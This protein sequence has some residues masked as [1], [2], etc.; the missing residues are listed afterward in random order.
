MSDVSPTPPD[1]LTSGAT[2]KITELNEGINETK[3]VLQVKVSEGKA[4]PKTIVGQHHGQDYCYDLKLQ[5]L[6]DQTKSV[7]QVKIH[8]WV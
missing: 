8:S 3:S 4:I 7:L 2:T 1:G 5:S 6:N